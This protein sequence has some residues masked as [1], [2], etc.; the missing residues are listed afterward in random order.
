VRRVV[1]A[2]DDPLRAGWRDV[3]AVA[4]RRAT[5]AA[6]AVRLRVAEA[7]DGRLIAALNPAAAH[8][9]VD[10]HLADPAVRTWIAERGSEPVGWAQVSVTN[11]VGELRGRVDGVDF[12]PLVR[13]ALAGDLQVR[14]LHDNRVNTGRTDG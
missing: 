14:E 9:P 7:G 5:F 2:L 11:G 4:G 3:L 10:R 8:A 1:A 12:V 6:H 13:R